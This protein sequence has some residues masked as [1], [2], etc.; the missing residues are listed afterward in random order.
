M[1][2]KYNEYTTE[3]Y[4]AKSGDGLALLLGL[5][6]RNYPSGWTQRV[7]SSTQSE[8]IVFFMFPHIVD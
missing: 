2:Q 6:T 4:P 3:F 5:S 1:I 8:M 7:Y